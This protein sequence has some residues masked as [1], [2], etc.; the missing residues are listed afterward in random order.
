MLAST[1]GWIQS[2]AGAGAPLATSRTGW[3]TISASS[4]PPAA[5][6]RPQLRAY[7]Q[8]LRRPA[9]AR[10]PASARAGRSRGDMLRRPRSSKRAPR[11]RPIRS[12]SAR[13][14]AEDL[15]RLLN[16]WQVAVP[17]KSWRRWSE[18][19]ARPRRSW[20]SCGRSSK[21]PGSH[22]AVSRAGTSSDEEEDLMEEEIAEIQKNMKEALLQIAERPPHLHGAHRGQRAGRGRLSPSSRRSSRPRAP[23]TE[24]RRTPRRS[25]C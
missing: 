3:P 16:Q 13:W 22:A 5:A 19:L 14:Q 21:A 25:A 10:S 1:R 23:R 6:S 20:R 4:S 24:A 8:D 18:A 7:G 12:R 17:R 15:S 11:R 9:P 2:G